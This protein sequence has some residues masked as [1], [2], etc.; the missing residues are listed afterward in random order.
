MTP[1]D[2]F[3]TSPRPRDVAAFGPARAAGLTPQVPSTPPRIS[4]QPPA[5]RALRD[6]ALL[7][8]LVVAA[9]LSV[10]IVAGQDGRLSGPGLGALLIVT[11]MG[12]VALA[13]SVRR[14]RGS[15]LA[16]LQRGYTTATFKL[17]RFWFDRSPDAPWTN[18]WVEWNWDATWVLRADG[19]VVSAP[20]GE[21]DPPGLYPS[22]HRDGAL[23]LWTGHQWSGYLPTGEHRV[24]GPA[25][26][27]RDA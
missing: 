9:I 25:S 4:V 8:G 5:R 3:V 24:P 20:S 16:E 15:Q 2:K 22:P 19:S 26:G 13:V 27:I 6:V 11:V 14:W 18:G 12:L 1:V 7:L 21:N 23:E 17:A 10:L